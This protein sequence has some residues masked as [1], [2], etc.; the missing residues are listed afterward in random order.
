MRV[1]L[2]YSQK[3]CFFEIQEL[4][5]HRPLG[6]KCLCLILP[7]QPHAHPQD[8]LTLQSW[9]MSNR[10]KPDFPT[11]VSSAQ[12]KPNVLLSTNQTCEAC[13]PNPLTSHRIHTS[14]STKHL[15]TSLH[16]SMFHSLETICIISHTHTH[17]SP[18]LSIHCVQ[19][20]H[21]LNKSWGQRLPWGGDGVHKSSVSTP[22]PLLFLAHNRW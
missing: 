20:L 5:P 15:C 4:L 19:F 3:P 17:P 18:I 16:W 11:P 22:F 13:T 8:T 12:E 6:L 14:D 10:W 1:W 2:Q 21:Q 7:L 9:N